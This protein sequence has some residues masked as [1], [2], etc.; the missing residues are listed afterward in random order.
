MFK[1][2][3][4][5]NA[6]FDLQHEEMVDNYMTEHHEDITPYEVVDLNRL[7]NEN[8]MTKSVEIW[9]IKRIITDFKNK[10]PGISKV[11]KTVLKNLPNEALDELMIVSNETISMGYFPRVYKKGMLTFANKPG[12]PSDNVENYRP[13]SLLE[14]PG[15][16]LEKIITNRLTRFLTNNNHINPNQ[17]GFTRGRGTHTALATIKETIAICQKNKN[18]CN[19]VARDVRKAFDK[20]WHNGLKYKIC[21]LQ[22]P[23]ISTKIYCN[24]LDDR[25]AVIKMGK[26][27][28]PEIS[29]QS[30]VPQGSILSPTLYNLYVKDLPPP[31]QG[32]LQIGFADDVTHIITHPNR[33]AKRTLALKTKREIEKV[34][35]YEH[36]WKI[37]TNINKFQ[38]LS[39]SALTPAEVVIN[40]HRINFS[41]NCTVLGFKMSRTGFTCHINDK[42]KKANL[43]LNKLR[44][45]KKLKTK[46][47]LY[48]FNALVRPSLEYP[49]VLMM[50]ARKT[51]IHR[52]QQVQNKA[53][54]RAFK[55]IPPY[56]TTIEEL[57][58]RAKQEPINVRLHR[59]AN[60]TWDRLSILNPELVERS[61][62]QND[63]NDHHWWTRISPLVEN[64]PPP[65]RYK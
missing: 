29:L 32:C 9:E 28:G 64:D 15:K 8:Y 49:A 63:G 11:N 17:H 59:L 10:A 62:E 50:T 35:S 36:K 34:N 25:K 13:L 16:I 57:H 48:L 40:N 6:N 51:N 33:K 23:E 41:N 58:L 21:H 24:F 19:I 56:Y 1:I 12:K 47:Q 38:L 54:R 37:S 52:L 60:K 39:I 22:L 53:V 7:S 55:E 65:P 26:F 2:T 44:R 31:A 27:I 43:D 4:E 30:G 45:F 3:P 14:V 42:I 18:G 61:R 46:T 20:V 5:E